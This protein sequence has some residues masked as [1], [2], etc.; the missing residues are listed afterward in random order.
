MQ[1]QE[2]LIYSIMLIYK[3]PNIVKRFFITQSLYPLTIMAESHLAVMQADYPMEINCCF[4]NLLITIYTIF[5]ILI[6]YVT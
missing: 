5:L 3:Y 6:K 1:I 2:M 4:Y